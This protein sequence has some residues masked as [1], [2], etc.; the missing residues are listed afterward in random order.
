MRSGEVAL[1]CLHS[2]FRKGGLFHWNQDKNAVKGNF[3]CHAALSPVKRLCGVRRKFNATQA[4]ESRL[5]LLIEKRRKLS[6][7]GFH[8]GFFPILQH[9]RA[10]QSLSNS[11]SAHPGQKNMEKRKARSVWQW[12]RLPR[13]NRQQLA[14]API[15][16]E[17]FLEANCNRRSTPCT[18]SSDKPQAFNLNIHPNPGT[19]S[20]T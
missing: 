10:P 3:A 4:S 8:Q 16:Y 15:A 11:S 14:C 17:T 7:T 9:F 5:G 2:L 13:I 20:K 12:L 1:N 18:I 19:S 6:T